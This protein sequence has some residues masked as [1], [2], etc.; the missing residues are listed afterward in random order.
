M[1]DKAAH[2]KWSKDHIYYENFVDPDL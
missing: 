2:K 1:G